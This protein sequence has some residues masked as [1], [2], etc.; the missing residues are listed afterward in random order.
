VVRVGDDGSIVIA[1]KAAPDAKVEI[2]SG[3]GVIG[4]TVAGPDG[5][6][7]IVLDEPLKPGAYQ[8]AIRST[9]PDNVVTTP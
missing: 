4:S 7:A 5:D 1:G 3:E 6:F 2:V 9:T 8:I